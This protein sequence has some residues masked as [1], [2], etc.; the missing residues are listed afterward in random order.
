MAEF[1]Q[2]DPLSAAIRN[3]MRGRRRRCAVAFW[4]AG[5]KEALFGTG[6]APSSAR[7]VCDLSMGGT[8]PAELMALGAPTNDAVR[9]VPGLHAKVYLSDRGAVVGSANASENG[10]GFSAGAGLVE[11]GVLLAPGTRAHAATAEWLDA[12]FEG[13]D[14]V[15]QTALDAC[16]E[17]WRR[18]SSAGR[19]RSEAVEPRPRSLLDAV[20]ADPARFRGIGFVFTDGSTSRRVRDLGS[21][22]IL[23][24]DAAAAA[25]A[26]TDEDRSELPVWPAGHVFSGWSRQDLSGW[27]ERFVCAHRGSSRIRYWF[28]ERR[29][30]VHLGDDEGGLVFAATSRPLRRELGLKRGADAMAEAD[31]RLLR[32]VF[33]R[34][35]R[36]GRHLYVNGDELAPLLDE[37]A[38]PRGR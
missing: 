25:P 28:Y 11:A 23:A 19:G 13:A 38:A 5:A 32:R 1:L 37:L 21:Q 26:L 9:H 27:P 24:A 17:A 22:T 10:I 14:V 18:R 7:V 12:L 36:T 2:G 15:D 34:M 3:V 35:R 31:D 4:G 20:R 30:V 8:N 29:H 6:R 33:A 16:T